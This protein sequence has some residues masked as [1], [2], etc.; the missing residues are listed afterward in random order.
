MVKKS[1]ISFVFILF[2][3][4]IRNDTAFRSGK[5]VQVSVRPTIDK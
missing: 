1:L 3:I 2:R 4:Y 5:N